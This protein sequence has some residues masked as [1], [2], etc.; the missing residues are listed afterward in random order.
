MCMWAQQAQM[1]YWSTSI[2]CTWACGSGS[3]MSRSGYCVQKSREYLGCTMRLNFTASYRYSVL[4]MPVSYNHLWLLDTVR[5]SEWW[6]SQ[7]DIDAYQFALTCYMIDTLR[8][9][10]M[11]P[12]KAANWQ[13]VLP[14]DWSGVF[15]MPKKQTLSRRPLH[16]LSRYDVVSNSRRSF[17]ILENSDGFDCGKG[18][19]RSL[20]FKCPCDNQHI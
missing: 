19:P 18:I 12:K 1:W 2:N 8:L 17:E 9:Q 10:I 14:Q 5:A 4:H 6:Q 20:K 13:F 7:T 11:E 3:G 15:W 16:R